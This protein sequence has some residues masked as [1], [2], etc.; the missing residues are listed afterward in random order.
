M[1]KVSKQAFQSYKKHF[2]E[3]SSYALMYGFIVLLVLVAAF[4]LPISLFLT[5][6]FVVVPFTYATQ[7]SMANINNGFPYS[8]G[9]LF[10]G[11]RIYFSKKGFGAY[12]TISSILKSILVYVIFYTLIGSI[13]LGIIISKDNS[14]S[15]LF[16]SISGIKTMDEYV[17]ILNDISQNASF[18]LATNIS[19][20]I[21]FGMGYYMFI[22]ASLVNSIK[23]EMSFYSI[24]EVDMGSIKM[25]HKQAF[26][27]IRKSFYQ[28]YYQSFFFIALIFVIGYASGVTLSNLFLT[29][30]QFYQVQIVGLASSF[31]LIMLFI[32]Y[33]FDVL[34]IIYKKHAQD[35]YQAGINSVLEA[36]D[37]LS[38]SNTLSPE[39]KETLD[40]LL[41]EHK[42]EAESKQK[43]NEKNER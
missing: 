27:I 2:G 3:K 19:S 21:A 31:V 5:I 29:N 14:L 11:Y 39:E 37:Q 34:E 16:D 23:A 17:K 10:Y 32:P 18:L 7:L 28:D 8:L 15:A 24:K 9:T 38:S 25:L 42:K 33:C 13:S 26:R 43:N 40:K 1:N 20:L 30:L 36:Y 35:Y 22:H 4:F 6:P 12:N 41:E